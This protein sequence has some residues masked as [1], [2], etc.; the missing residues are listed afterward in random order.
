MFQ[1]DLLDRFGNFLFPLFLI[2]ARDVGECAVFK[3]F[4]CDRK[5]LCEFFVGDAVV[6]AIAGQDDKF[7]V[8]DFHTA[9]FRLRDDQLVF[10]W[11]LLVQLLGEVSEGARQVQVGVDAVVAHEAACRLDAG[12]LLAV[13]G[14]VILRESE[15][16]AVFELCDPPGVASVGTLKLAVFEQTYIGGAASAEWNRQFQNIVD[17]WTLELGILVHDFL[18]RK[19]LGEFLVLLQH[20]V[21]NH[22]C[23]VDEV[24]LVERHV[25][26]EVDVGGELVS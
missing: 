10:D 19:V 11:V 14:L 9:H 15:C 8:G 20:F 12:F 21:F 6:D 18:G 22:D 16:G 7:A 5:P 25:G 3:F 23:E 2:F 17:V 26:L 13:V 24:F 1:F 4:E